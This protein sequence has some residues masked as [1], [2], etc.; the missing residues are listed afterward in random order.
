MLKLDSLSLFILNDADEMLS[1]DI[2]AQTLEILKSLPTGI[3][4]FLCS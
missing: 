1:G 3:Q 2:K 4:V